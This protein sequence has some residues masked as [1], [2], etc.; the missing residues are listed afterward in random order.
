MPNP[1]YPADNTFVNWADSDALWGPL[2]FLRPKPT[3]PLDPWRIAM[4][5]LVIGSF[6]GM[7]INVGMVVAK[8]LTGQAIPPAYLLPVVLTAMLATMLGMSV[9]P[10]WN[11]R[12]ERL[13][14]RSARLESGE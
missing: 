3:K 4:I 11:R 6:Q 9:A 13:A 10:A 5:A 1:S 7:A 8:R 12:A 14:R 2:L